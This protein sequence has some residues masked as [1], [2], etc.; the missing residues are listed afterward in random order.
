MKMTK[1]DL[2]VEFKL[3]N[4]LVKY[5]IMTEWLPFWCWRK[6]TYFGW[7]YLWIFKAEP[8]DVA[9]TSSPEHWYAVKDLDMVSSFTTY[10]Q[11]CRGLEDMNQAEEARFLNHERTDC[12]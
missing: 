2:P 8:F 10:G 7:H 3:K 12:N 9:D 6:Y 4:G 11:L 5:R 1:N